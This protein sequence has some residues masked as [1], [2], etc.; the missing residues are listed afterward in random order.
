MKYQK[1]LTLIEM[2][3]AISLLAIMISAIVFSFDGSKSRAQVMIAAMTAYAGAMERMKSD[4]ACYPKMLP[5][6]FDRS[7]AEGATASYCGA[8]L[9]RQWNGPYVKTAPTF[10]APALGD[11]AI[12]S[13]SANA[14]GGAAPREGVIALGQISPDVTLRT[15]RAAS[16]F[17]GAGGPG[18]WKWFIIAD[19]VPSEI[20]T[21]ALAVCNGVDDTLQGGAGAAGGVRKCAVEGQN[22]GYNITTLELRPRTDDQPGSISMLFAETRR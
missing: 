9:S 1:G 10:P 6:L 13:T 7:Y 19:G 2:V 14:G 17:G 5:A 11:P 4:T 8:D 18:T 3:I 16:N 20:L 21:Q 12:D 22:P 15:G